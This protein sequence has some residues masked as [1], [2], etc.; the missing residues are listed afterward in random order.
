MFQADC[1]LCAFSLSHAFV[2]TCFLPLPLLL[3]L[4]L[5]LFVVLLWKV[6]LLL[7]EEATSRDADDAARAGVK[8]RRV[9]TSRSSGVAL[10]VRK[11]A[12]PLDDVALRRK[13]ALLLLPLL[14]LLL[15]LL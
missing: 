13:E 3:L 7:S 2:S 12:R 14:L 5:L 8:L 1:A 9:K 11:E 4:T 6:A 15:P 10:R